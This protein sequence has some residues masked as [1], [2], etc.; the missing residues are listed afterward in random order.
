[1]RY[2]GTKVP[3]MTPTLRINIRDYILGGGSR[4]SASFGCDRGASRPQP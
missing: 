4:V 2:R 1:M 3:P